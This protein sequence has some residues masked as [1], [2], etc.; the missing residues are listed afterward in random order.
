MSWW[1]LDSAGDVDLGQR[2]KG[3]SGLEIGSINTSPRYIHQLVLTKQIKDDLIQQTCEQGIELML[4]NL[5]DNLLQSF[6][7]KKVSLTESSQLDPGV[8]QEKPGTSWSIID[9]ILMKLQPSASKK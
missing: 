6:K 7:E 5:D 3:L 4:E 2:K 1:T 8:C 9:M